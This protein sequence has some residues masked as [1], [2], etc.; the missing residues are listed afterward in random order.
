MGIRNT[1][2]SEISHS[3]Q[4]YPIDWHNAILRG[5]RCLLGLQSA[6]M[7]SKELDLCR[8]AA[9]AGAAI[10][11]SYFAN[12]AEAGIENKSSTTGYQGIV[13][14]ADIEAERAI[15]E[16]IQEAFPHHSF[17]GEES[18]STDTRSGSRPTI[19]EHLWIIDPIDGTNNFAHGIPHFAVSVAYYRNGV[20]EC[21]CVLSPESRDEFWAQRGRGAFH[22]GR[23]AQVNQHRVLSETMLGT[24]FYYD[25]GSMMRATLAAIGDCFEQQIHGIR[26]M[27]TAALDI[28][29]VGLGRFGGF[30]EFQLAPW[31][32]AAARIFLEEAGGRITTCQGAE[33]PIA[34]TSV[35]ASN[36]HL[37]AELLKI[38][39]RHWDR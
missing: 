35:L 14:K 23:R 12:L 29:Y 21:G 39:G 31:D 20:A 27:G 10:A 13:T 18:V 7:D 2:Y 34:K 28:V 17:L 15:I 16:T 36:G 5:F 4:M 33:L 8:C 30:F 22:N 11:R 38:V 6:S 24:G 9:A 26:R 19:P 37:H 3:H 1:A 32:F 25:R